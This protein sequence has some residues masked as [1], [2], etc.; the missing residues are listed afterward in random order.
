MT[1]LPHRSGPVATACGTLAALV[2]S[3]TVPTAQGPDPG[4]PSHPPKAHVAG[5]AD[6]PANDASSQRRGFGAEQVDRQT[7][8]LPLGASGRLEL[9][10]ARGDISVITGEEPEVVVE[11]ER[12]AHGRSDADARLGLAQVTVRVDHQGDHAII[13]TAHEDRRAPFSVTV[14]YRVTAPA[15][16][17]VMLRNVAG[18]LTVQGIQGQLSVDTVAGQ[19]R[20]TDCGRVASVRSI[21]GPILL[22]NVTSDGSIEIES[23]DGTVT[24][25]QVG[26]RRLAVES[27]GGT[28]AARQVTTDMLDLRS[29]GGDV[30]FTGAL[31]PSGRYEFQSYSGSITLTVPASAGFTLEAGTFSGEIRPAADLALTPTAETRRSLRATAGDGRAHVS[32]TTFSGAIVIESE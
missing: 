16:T 13:E 30:V 25:E 20:V 19:V 4:V 26:A 10:N 23:V 28:I 7:Y 8:R 5:W 29:M 3:A 9:R 18:Q 1:S 6:P 22:S 11:V 14:H 32:A 17:R 21:S 15:G 27:V 31:A 2:L 12:L 24:L